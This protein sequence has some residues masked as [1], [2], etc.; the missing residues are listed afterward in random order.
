MNRITKQVGMKMKTTELNRGSGKIKGKARLMILMSGKFFS[1]I[2]NSPTRLRRSHIILSY[3]IWMGHIPKLQ[4]FSR[5]S[6]FIYFN[7]Q[8]YNII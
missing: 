2:F 8:N 4:I 6:I 5:R 3:S 1:D 7:P